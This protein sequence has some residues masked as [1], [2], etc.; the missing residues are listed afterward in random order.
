MSIG[1]AVSITSPDAGQVIAAASL[2]AQQRGERCFVISVVHSL[3]APRSH[4]EEEVAAQNLALIMARNA[5]P[6]VQ[7]A[8]DVPTAIISA[9]R[10]FGIDTLFVGSPKLRVLRRSVPEKLVR[11]SPP[12]QIVVVHRSG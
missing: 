9:A 6:I 8:D 2:L 1:A 7:E 4:T 11:L 10:S 12:F 3:D 5:A